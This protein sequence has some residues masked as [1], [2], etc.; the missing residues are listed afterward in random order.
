MDAQIAKRLAMALAAKGINMKQAGLAAG[1]SSNYVRDVLRRG[2]GKFELLERVA[3]ANGLS[4]PWIKTGE[5]EMEPRK[6]VKHTA[7][8]PYYREQLELAR[9]KRRL[10][11]PEPAT[12]EPVNILV[13][14]AALLHALQMFGASEEQAV[15][16]VEFL[17]ALANSHKANLP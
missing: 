9:E 16:A 10:P 13:D 1:L 15:R 3:E 8:P 6:G 14:R 2:R 7:A 4:W 11:S 12:E 5:G 17:S